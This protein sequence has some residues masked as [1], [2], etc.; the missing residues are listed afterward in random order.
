MMI[1]SYNGMQNT[2]NRD[3][4][5]FMRDRLH[6]GRKPDPQVNRI[7]TGVQT[8]GSGSP[9]ITADGFQIPPHPPCRCGGYP[10]TNAQGR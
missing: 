9:D 7:A 3:A 5:F 4:C 8:V 1:V 2:Q 10:V 6:R